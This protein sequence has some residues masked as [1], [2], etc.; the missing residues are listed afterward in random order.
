MDRS[1][2]VLNI[3]TKFELIYTQRIEELN[4]NR[5]IIEKRK[6]EH[7]GLIKKNNEKILNIKEE[8]NACLKIEKEVNEEIIYNEFLKEA[9][10]NR[11]IKSYVFE[12]IVNEINSKSNEFLGYLFDSQI[13]I[14]FRV[15]NTKNRNGEYNNKFETKILLDNVE[16]EIGSFSGGERR[17]IILAVD[18]AVSQIIQN[19]SSKSINLL[20]FDEYFTGLDNSG[21]ERMLELLKKIEDVTILVID[22]STSFQNLFDKKIEVIKENKTSRII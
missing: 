7:T 10:G 20:I 18:L 12:Q 3:Q 5:D 15:K 4:K 21:K 8:L 13:L 1:L 17:R 16:K 22:H 2:D 11:G 14:D 19:R 9:F 6:N